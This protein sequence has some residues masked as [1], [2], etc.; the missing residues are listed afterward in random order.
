MCLAGPG[1]FR[2]LTVLDTRKVLV[3]QGHFSLDDA[4]TLHPGERA[5]GSTPRKE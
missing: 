4:L 2:A 5:E 3:L 1:A